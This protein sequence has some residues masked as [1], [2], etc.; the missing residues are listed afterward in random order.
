M[1]SYSQIVLLGALFVNEAK[2]E[3]LTNYGIYSLSVLADSTS[4]KSGNYM[5]PLSL[6]SAKMFNLP[7]ASFRFHITMYTLAIG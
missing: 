6:L 1:P 3:T 2:L 4:T 7:R 5:L